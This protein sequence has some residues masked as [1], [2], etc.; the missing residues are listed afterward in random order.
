MLV[1]A[2]FS[3]E[4][5]GGRHLGLMRFHGCNRSRWLS[6]LS[7][8]LPPLRSWVRALYRASDRTWEEFVNT[9]P[10]VVGFLRLLRFPPTG[11][12]DRVG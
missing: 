2:I 3:F 6:R 10:K 11:K 7:D 12:V 9:L 1:R 8:V 5:R 4:F